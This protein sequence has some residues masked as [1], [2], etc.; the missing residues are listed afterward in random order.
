M[1]KIAIAALL[2][3]TVLSSPAV[4]DEDGLYGSLFGGPS[5]VGD[6]TYN[7]DGGAD[8]FGIDGGLAGAVGAN[9]GYDYGKFR[10]ELE[11][12]FYNQSVDDVTLI[13]GGAASS[14]LGTI[15]PGMPGGGGEGETDPGTPD[16]LVPLTGTQDAQGNRRAITAMVN[17]IFDIESD[18]DWTPFLGAGVGWGFVGNRNIRTVA[19]EILDDNSSGPAVQVM[20]GVRRKIAEAID[21]GVQFRHTRIFA[22]DV[23]AFG[24]EHDD[25]FKATSL[26]ASLNFYFDRQD[27]APP[28]PPPPAPAYVAPPPPPPPPAPVAV[29]VPGPFLVFFDWD[30]ANITP[31]A[32][33]IIKDAAEAYREYGQST[34]ML[35]G[36][37]DTSGAKDYN[38]RLSARRASAV[39]A[40]LAKYGVSADAMTKQAFG[41]GNLRVNTFDGVREPQNRRV[42]ITLGE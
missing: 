8:S 15:I 17:G 42:Q 29:A 28:P 25:S 40:E 1:R 34:I 33:A 5:I 21:F 16:M 39:E 41:E 31:E 36:F 9:L 14:A 26:L 37:A 24:A 19:G 35:E 12:A 22:N 20:A 27:A 11:S 30:E 3:G 23:S 2:G 4:A 6:E 32:A 38:D 18:S 13:P 7:P 10:L